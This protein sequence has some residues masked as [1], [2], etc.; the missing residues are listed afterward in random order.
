MR[1]P[2]LVALLLTG[3]AVADTDA[4]SGGAAGGDPQALLLDGVAWSLDWDLSGTERTAGGRVF[5]SDLGY[6]I[7]LTSAVVVTHSLTLDPCDEVTVTWL[8]LLGIGSA[9]AHHGEFEDP[10]LVEWMVGE[11]L[12]DPGE[13]TTSFRFDAARYCGV[14]WSMARPDPKLQ[15]QDDNPKA[16]V[17]LGLYGTWTRGEASG[18]IALSSD[19]P[20]G[21]GREF[22]TQIAIPDDVDG[23]AID[24]H[25]VRELR[26]M[27]DGIDLAI[28][29]DNQATWA[30]LE[31][32]VGHYRVEAAS[33]AL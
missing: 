3:C 6:E 12:V 8:D 25:L 17:N 11:D 32:L 7:T 27:F 18:A 4:V 31:N 20:D 9:H 1:I 30:V 21:Q 15:G 14:H 26:S 28:A 16:R 13:V 23:G 22:G 10:S 5:T 19:W 24:L 33:I 2:L 29:T